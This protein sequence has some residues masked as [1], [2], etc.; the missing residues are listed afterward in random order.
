MLLA[1]CAQ[2]GSLAERAV[3]AAEEARAASI[4]NPQRRQQFLAGRCLL[5]RLLSALPG[6]N[7]PVAI[8]VPI[9]VEAGQA[10]RIVT[11]P[12]LYLSV[13]H[14]GDLVAAALSSAPVGIDVQ[15]CRP[16]RPFADLA[17][18]AMSEVEWQAWRVL[19]AEDQPAAF[20][21]SWCG[22]EAAYK[23]RPGAKLPDLEL[24]ECLDGG[25]LHCWALAAGEAGHTPAFLAICS[26]LL[27]HL[28]LP[29]SDLRL[30]EPGWGFRVLA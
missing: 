3:D 16:G 23:A 18:W 4:R 8:R 10:P 12:D 5:R 2:L 24:V 29:R 14:S 11:R 13:S 9:S 22:K 26:S 21:R 7:G 30:M 15:H 28:R 27:P 1:A 20:Y 17:R 19:P 6:M 25:D